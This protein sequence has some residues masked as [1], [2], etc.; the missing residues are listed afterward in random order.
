MF[1]RKMKNHVAKPS[2]FSTLTISYLGILGSNP[3]E[4]IFFWRYVKI[5]LK[6]FCIVQLDDF[7]TFLNK[8]KL[9]R[10]NKTQ[11]LD[12]LNMFFYGLQTSQIS[13]AEWVI[14]IKYSKIAN[15]KKKFGKRRINVG[16]CFSHAKLFP[17]GIEPR[18]TCVIGRC[19]N[20][21]TKETL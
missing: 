14:S 10:C 2:L 1:W 20:H 19:D 5:V 6:F 3:S 17:P 16:T 13:A 4:R 12:L 7:C 21:Y 9:S 18:T 8:I 15:E 11:T